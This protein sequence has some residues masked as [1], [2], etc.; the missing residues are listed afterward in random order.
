ME[1]GGKCQ[2]LVVTV[3]PASIFPFVYSYKVHQVYITLSVYHYPSWI[4]SEKNKF[5]MISAK[6]WNSLLLHN[7]PN[8]NYF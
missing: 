1:Q 6:Y 7:I 4:I 8:G 2:S 3:S 5:T